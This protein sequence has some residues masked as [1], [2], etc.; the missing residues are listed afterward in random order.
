MKIQ[1]KYLIICCVLC[2]C[3]IPELQA[4]CNKKIDYIQ[5]VPVSKD[6]VWRKRD[7]NITIVNP[8]NE[9]LLVTNASYDGSHGW[10]R[11]WGYNDGIVV[12]A[13]SKAGA[14]IYGPG[15]S[16]ALSAKNA[17]G[18][19][20][21][22]HYAPIQKKMYTW[23]IGSKPVPPPVVEVTNVTVFSMAGCGTSF[24]ELKNYDGTYPTRKAPV[25]SCVGRPIVSIAT[26]VPKNRSYIKYDKTNLVME[27]GEEY[28]I[29]V[30]FNNP[31][32][33]YKASKLRFFVVPLNEPSAKEA[34]FGT[35]CNIPKPL[36]SLTLELPEK[37]TDGK[38]SFVF[39][40]TGDMAGKTLYL[41]FMVT[42]KSSK[43]T[44]V[45]FTVK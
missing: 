29:Q 30:N 2:L 38:E 15:I 12:K 24:H 43:Y 26:S 3:V 5:P 18:K 27:Q 7:N 37:T 39:R 32:D 25:K 41:K 45:K 4:Y 9:D 13:N 14:Y 23:V 10:V 35:R 44:Y 6:K 21:D 20:I 16:I 28:V 40:P 34:C 19:H 22:D 33:H 42:S 31:F 8:T 11:M 36:M 17:C 1:L